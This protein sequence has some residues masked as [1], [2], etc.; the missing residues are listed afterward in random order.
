MGVI[1]LT[2]DHFCHTSRTPEPV[3]LLGKCLRH[4]LLVFKLAPEIEITVL[5]FCFDFDN[6]DFK[7][8]CFIFFPGKGTEF[9]QDTTISCANI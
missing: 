8:K 2:S 1:C 4:F 9:R 5:S 6:C 3:G 7:R